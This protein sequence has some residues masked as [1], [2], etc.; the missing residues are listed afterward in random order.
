M[1]KFSNALFRKLPF[2]ALRRIDSGLYHSPQTS[3]QRR[4]VYMP[5]NRRED[6]AA[7][8]AQLKL[9]GVLN[10][11]DIV[12]IDGRSEA[13]TAELL[14]TARL[15]LRFSFREGFG[16]PPLEALASGCMVVGNHGFGGREYFQ[17]PFAIAVKAATSPLLCAR[18]RRPS[19]V[20][21][22]IHIRADSIGAA[23]SRF[24]S[25]RYALE[26]EKQDLIN[27]FRPLLQ[28]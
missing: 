15:F 20:S 1:P 24:V 23:A 4:L 2:G 27:I 12:A 13:E 22:L 6:A 10:G 17:P 19:T 16:L 3:K 9:R 7:L 8:L 11:W 25:E 18:W 28:P 26:A 5:R 14:R 21:R